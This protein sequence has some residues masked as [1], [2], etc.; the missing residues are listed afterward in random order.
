MRL[1]KLQEKK[2]KALGPKYDIKPS[3]KYLL[4]KFNREFDQLKDD[5]F[6]STNASLTSKAKE[7]ADSSENIND[8][9]Q[10]QFSPNTIKVNAA[11]SETD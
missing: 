4:L 3:D 10:Q 11:V 6:Q 1:K 8:V 5:I 2:E 9:E 7:G